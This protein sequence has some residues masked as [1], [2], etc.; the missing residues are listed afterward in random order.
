METKRRGRPPGSFKKVK[1][2]ESIKEPRTRDEVIQ[3][4]NDLGY[5]PEP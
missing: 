2:A 4:F 3:R 5:N 1:E